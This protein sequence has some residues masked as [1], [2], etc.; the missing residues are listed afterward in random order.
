MM[1]QELVGQVNEDAPVI[2]YGCPDCQYLLTIC[3]DNDRPRYFCENCDQE[4][5]AR[6][7]DDNHISDDA[8]PNRGIF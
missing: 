7:L 1:S 2:D 6:E 8:E 3:Y 5:S 4:I